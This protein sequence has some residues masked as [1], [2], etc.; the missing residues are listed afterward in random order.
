VVGAVHFYVWTRLVQGAELALAFHALLTALFF[1]GYLLAGAAFLARITGRIVPRP[2]AAAGFTWLGVLFLGFG[3]TLLTVPLSLATALTVTTA[4][5]YGLVQARVPT[6][7]LVRAPVRGLDPRLSGYRLVQLSDVHI[8]PT[9]GRSFVERLVQ[10]ANAQDPDA[11][12]ITGDL[13]DGTVDELRDAAA[14]LAGLRARDGVFFVTGNHEYYSGAPQWVSHLRTLGIQVLRNERVTI[15]RDGASFDLVGVDDLFG[16]M[17][18]GHG[19]DLDEALAGR[20]PSRPA[21]LL[22]HQPT[23]VR[24]AAKRG[25]AL[26]LSGHTHGGQLFPFTFLVG[27]VQPWMSGLHEVGDTTLYVHRGTGYWGPPMRVG[28]PGEIARIELQTA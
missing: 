5:I 11:I 18:P 19:I 9:V 2:V 3:I 26:Q 23:V 16:S 15:E 10:Q 8:G 17:V 6:T 28:A 25:V 22:A 7:P 21:V 4:A 24:E 27:L 20:D 1:G 13:V 12:V 14:P